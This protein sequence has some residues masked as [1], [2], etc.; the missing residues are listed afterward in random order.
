MKILIVDDDIV[1][2]SLIAAI[3]EKSG[4]MTLKASSAKEAITHLE[5]G[6]PVRVVIADVMMP[7]MNGMELVSYMKRN[8][9]L[10]G[11][12]VIVCSGERNQDSIVKA[13]QAGVKDYI[14]KPIDAKILL[15]KVDNVLKTYS[16]PIV[17]KELIIEKL[18]IDYSTYEELFNKLLSSTSSSLQYY[19]ELI[20]N[21]NFDQLKIAAFS[22]Q[23][24][25][26]NMGAERLA[27][28]L[29]MCVEAAGN[30]DEIKV[31]VMLTLVERELQILKD[32]IGKN[33][34][35]NSTWWVEYSQHQKELNKIRK[36]K[37]EI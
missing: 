32:S 3:L 34:S 29:E 14:V 10:R 7:D 31:N 9:V 5:S 13:T 35:K 4:Y 8:A 21:K 6:E 1:S 15:G 22:L 11:I 18:K 30:Q 37:G 20:S 33:A 12:P 27:S 2:L 23:G 36:L 17:D 16:L 19:K 24:G 25:A 28:V 26:R